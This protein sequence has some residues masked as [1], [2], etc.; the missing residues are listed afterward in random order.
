MDGGD[1]SS[2][3]LLGV[4]EGVS[5]DS[6]GSLVS[7]KLDG[8]D[9]TLDNLPVSSTRNTLRRQRSPRARYQSTLPRCS[10]GSRP[11]Y[12]RHVANRERATTYSVN[13]VVSG[14]VSF[15]GDTRP[16]VGEQGE[17]PSQRQVERDVSLS[18][19][20][21]KGT[22]EGDGVLLD[23]VDGG[24]GD[25]GLAVDKDG[26]DVNL[27][28]L[29]RGLGSEWFQGCRRELEE[30][31]GER[32]EREWGRERGGGQVRAGHSTKHT[33]AARK[34]VLTDSAISGPIPGNEQR[35]PDPFEH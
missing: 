5:G 27:F 11:V 7:D 33:L 1:L 18:D 9:N 10:L 25:S 29:D 32:Y 24:L 21:S 15:Y 13:I 14:L 16:D 19:G 8:L 28:P 3:V 35:F 17:G 6:L 12:Q 30:G 23:A 31:G 2:A 22:L 4:V 26:G 34:M 20:G